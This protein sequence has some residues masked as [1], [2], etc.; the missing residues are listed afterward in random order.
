V[1]RRAGGQEAKPEV[2]PESAAKNLGNPD[3]GPTAS[4][5]ATPGAIP[6]FFRFACS[7]IADEHRDRA[8]SGLVRGTS[9]SRRERP[10]RAFQALT[11]GHFT[12]DVMP[13]IAYLDAGILD[14][15]I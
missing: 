8:G 13:V 5:T 12:A 4:Q 6:E 11:P 1:T 10:Q 14:A 3:L 15:G 9:G 2:Q 7:P